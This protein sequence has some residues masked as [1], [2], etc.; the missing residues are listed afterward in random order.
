[1]YVSNPQKIKG[2]V[3]LK[4]ENVTPEDAVKDLEAL[5]DEDLGGISGGIIRRSGDYADSVNRR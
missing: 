3:T 4:S 2:Q 1:M 5:S